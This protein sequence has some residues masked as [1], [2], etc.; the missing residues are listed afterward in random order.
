MS[1]PGRPAAAGQGCESECAGGWRFFTFSCGRAGSLLKDTEHYEEGR[2]N[3]HKTDGRRRRRIGRRQRTRETDKEDQ[4]KN[5]ETEEEE[6]I[7]RQ[8]RNTKQTEQ[9]KTK[10][11][12]KTTRRK[13]RSRKITYLDFLLVFSKKLHV[14]R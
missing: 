8:K 14:F 2:G 13:R 3:T 4:K 9:M 5:P 10:K 11:R 7:I 1:K 6:G 12:K